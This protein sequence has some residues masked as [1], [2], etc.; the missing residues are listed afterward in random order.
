MHIKIQICELRSTRVSST[1]SLR[2]VEARK[3][4]LTCQCQPL[5]FLPVNMTCPCQVS[6]WNVRF[7]IR[8]S[9][10]CR[11]RAGM[12][13]CRG[14]V[15]LGA[16]G[17]VGAVD[18][19]ESPSERSERPMAT[20]KERWQLKMAN[21]T[22]IKEK[23]EPRLTNRIL[24]RGKRALI[25]IFFPARAGR[26]KK[27]KREC[28]W[29]PPLS[30]PVTCL[31]PQLSRFRAVSHPPASKH[32]LIVLCVARHALSNRLVCLVSTPHLLPN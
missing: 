14:A 30:P 24:V 11:I 31:S 32:G 19:S 12:I 6:P 27:Q 4:V 5:P 25:I 28:M 9:W 18:R 2:G 16:V 10:R 22:G 17:V 7:P 13:G 15:W 23:R 20:Q 21:N 8:K 3:Q 29:G 26:G 1:G